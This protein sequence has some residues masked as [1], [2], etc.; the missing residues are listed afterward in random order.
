MVQKNP[1]RKNCHIHLQ[2]SIQILFL[3]VRLTYQKLILLQEDNFVKNIY[4]DL[5]WN[6]N[7]EIQIIQNLIKDSL[8]AQL[9]DFGMI[10]V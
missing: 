5:F 7:K 4:P 3:V 8:L 9:K 10:D 2:L 6:I 1:I